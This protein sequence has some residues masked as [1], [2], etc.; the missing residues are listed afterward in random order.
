MIPKYSKAAVLRKFGEPLKIEKVK[1]PEQIEANAILVK[2]K[3]S[4]ICGTDVH[5]WQGKLNL[6]VDLPVILGHE[7]VGEIVQLGENVRF[8]SLGTPLKTGDRVIWAHGDC[9]NCYYCT[10][11]KKPTL[12]INRKQ[13]M[14][15]N[16][17]KFPYLMGGFSEYGYIL[18][19]SG[20]VK[21]PEA[22]SDELA[23][24]CSCAFRSVMNSFNQLGA[25]RSEDSIVIQGT[26][27]LGLLA[28]AVAKKAGAKNVIA[29][30]GPKDRLKLASDMGADHII[31][32]S[33]VPSTLE[34]QNKILEITTNL[35][36]DIVMEYSGFP[37]AVEEGLQYIR[38]NG[39]Y[40]I[41]GQLG[42]GTVEIMPSIITA[43][44]LTLI[45]SYSGD[46]SHYDQALKFIDKYQ[47]EIPFN[48]LITNRYK[49][50][51][52]NL[53]LENMKSFKEI[54]PLIIL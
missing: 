53:A 18:P 52:I 28:I 5:L 46:I 49:L 20:R 47:N 32:I 38:K 4:S 17:E 40:V 26:G 42:Q 50:E 51:D 10:I 33:E 34:R 24:L 48:N 6:K 11:E 30:G 15:E 13:Y 14:Y 31:D 35:G 22:V 37:G 44:N 36:A 19:N 54:K 27:P 9:G 16:M 25:I 21:I 7:M 41:V 45:G 39:R 1:I 29:I 12:C 8:D 23:S 2:N 3:I 43:K